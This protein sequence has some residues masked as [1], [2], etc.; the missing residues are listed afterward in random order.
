MTATS[1]HQ[2]PVAKEQAASGRLLWAEWIKFRTVRGWLIALSPRRRSHVRDSCYRGGS[3]PQ[4]PGCS[5]FPSAG[6]ATCAP[7]TFVPT[8]PGGEAVADTY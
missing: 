2:S 1:A 5:G 6:L 4:H 7:P 3:R 8:G